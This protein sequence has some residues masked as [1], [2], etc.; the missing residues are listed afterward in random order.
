MRMAHRRGPG[1]RQRAVCTACA[2]LALLALVALPASSQEATFPLKSMT[3]EAA[4][5]AARAALE[6]CR[7]QG[8]QVTV[9]VVDRSG[10]LQALVRDRFAGAHTVEVA[11]NK[12][13]T[14]ASFKLATA[15]LALETQA[16]K[17]MSGIRAHP[18]VLAAGG[19]Q[20]IQAGGVLLGGI[21]VSGAPG[22]EMDDACA[23][24]GIRAI[25]ESLEF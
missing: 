17:P 23:Q 9:A 12:A 20:P 25:A 6:H 8:Y 5:S 2:M 16:G 10:L 3:P 14:A 15:A 7:K 13:W 1:W 19:G 21:G 4:V 24:A 11:T 18:H 22:G